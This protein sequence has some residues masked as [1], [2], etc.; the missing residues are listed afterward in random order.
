M[1]IFVF[2]Y[3]LWN[4]FV[5]NVYFNFIMILST[6]KGH[7]SSTPNRVEGYIHII[8]HFLYSKFVHLL[9]LLQRHMLIVSTT[10]AELN[11]VVSPATCAKFTDYVKSDNASQFYLALIFIPINHQFAVQIPKCPNLRF[12]KVKTILSTSTKCK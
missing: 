8:K 1:S 2:G 7:S 11:P 4:I 5:S 10:I 6:L 12:N 3:I 9:P